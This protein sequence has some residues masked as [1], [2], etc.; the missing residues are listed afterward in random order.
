MARSGS[1]DQWCA[2]AATLSGKAVSAVE[3]EIERRRSTCVCRRGANGY[4]GRDG[5]AAKARAETVADETSGGARGASS[6]AIRMFM[7]RPPCA[8]AE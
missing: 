3:I 7:W 1:R 5:E 6:S 8:G 2:D 4:S